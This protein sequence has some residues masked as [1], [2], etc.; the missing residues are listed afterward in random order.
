MH[1][2]RRKVQRKQEIKV[3]HPVRNQAQNHLIRG[4]NRLKQLHQE[5]QINRNL[6]ELL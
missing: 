6:K 3:H 5:E 4:S 1:I 2:I